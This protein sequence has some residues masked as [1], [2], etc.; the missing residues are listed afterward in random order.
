MLIN[1]S[2]IDHLD[3]FFMRL[4]SNTGKKRRM[5]FAPRGKALEAGCVGGFEDYYNKHENFVMGLGAGDDEIYRYL[6]IYN[7]EQTA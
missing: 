1:E 2:F 6:V 5:A 4:I 3:G 7:D